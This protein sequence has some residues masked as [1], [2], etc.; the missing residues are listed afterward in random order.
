MKT[1]PLN[2]LF[3]SQTREFLDIYP[4][5]QCSRSPHTVKAYRDALTG[6]YNRAKCEHIFEILNRDDSD[7]AIVSI[8]VNGLKY[9]NDNFGHSMGE[10][11]DA[12]T[13]IAVAGRVLVYPY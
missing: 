10:T 1:K 5:S 4:V 7:Y 13:P 9:V 3:F 8:D 12:Q 11:D 2:E 6:I